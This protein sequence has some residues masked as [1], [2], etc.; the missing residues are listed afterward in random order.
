MT[1]PI[2]K[3]PWSRAQKWGSAAPATGFKSKQLAELYAMSP[4]Q[5]ER[6]CQRELGRSP[7]EWLDEQRMVAARLL[8][9]HTDSVKR[10]ALELGYK[11]VNHFSRHFKQYYRMTPSQYLSLY[12]R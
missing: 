8:L 11:Q 1:V 6:L 12:R 4:R 9:L 7:Q 2:S 5:M 10:S 3:L